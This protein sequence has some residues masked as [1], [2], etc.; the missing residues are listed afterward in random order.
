MHW[1]LSYNGTS[2]I[3]IILFLPFWFGKPP[4]SSAVSQRGNDY[5]VN[6]INVHA[7]EEKEEKRLLREVKVWHCLDEQFHI[8]YPHFFFS[9]I[10]IQYKKK[11]FFLFPPLPPK[12][13]NTQKHCIHIQKKNIQKWRRE[14]KVMGGRLL[15]QQ[16]NRSR[17]ESLLKSAP[18]LWYSSWLYEHSDRNKV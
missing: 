14:K 5:T 9:H 4:M 15:L 10:Y 3:N 7:E 16:L 11:V 6:K 2:P 8:F 12:G 18:A 17:R 13:G 1:V